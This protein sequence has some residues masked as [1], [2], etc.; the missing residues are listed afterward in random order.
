ME[1]V[2]HLQLMLLLFMLLSRIIASNMSLDSVH[3]AKRRFADSFNVRVGLCW[4]LGPN[5]LKLFFYCLTL[6]S[7]MFEVCR[8]YGWVNDSI[9]G[10]AAAAQPATPRRFAIF[11]FHNV[12][13]APYVGGFGDRMSG[14]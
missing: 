13:L 3:W 9:N 11:V 5:F 6:T 12:S 1:S 2:L 7:V 8:S 10:M 14:W 4:L